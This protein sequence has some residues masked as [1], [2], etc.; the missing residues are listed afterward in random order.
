MGPAEPCQYLQVKDLRIST[1]KIPLVLGLSTCLTVCSVSAEF[2]MQYCSYFARGGKNKK[3]P[4]PTQQNSYFKSLSYFYFSNQIFSQLF[5]F[6]FFLY[7]IFIF[8]FLVV[9]QQPYMN[10]D[11]TAVQVKIC[12]L[13]KIYFARRVS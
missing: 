5:F 6:W 2:I 10:T 4:K 12:L 13:S 3:I 7:F 11:R 8:P 1:I 9:G